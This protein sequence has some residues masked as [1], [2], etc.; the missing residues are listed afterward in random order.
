MELISLGRSEKKGFGRPQEE[1]QATQSQ[2]SI[3]KWGLSLVILDR[4]PGLAT[5]RCTVGIGTSGQP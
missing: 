1:G 2:Q 3:N 4:L 5:L